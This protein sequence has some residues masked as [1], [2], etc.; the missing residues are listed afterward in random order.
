MNACG[1]AVNPS[2]HRRHPFAANA[3]HRSSTY[4]SL[5]GTRIL[6]GLG[7]RGL[8]GSGR[9]VGGNVASLHTARVEG[10]FIDN[11]LA[12]ADKQGGVAARRDWNC[13]GDRRAGRKQLLWSEDG[14]SAAL[15]PGVINRS[16]PQWHLGRTV[17]PTEA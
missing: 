13:N 10:K 8:N 6:P 11:Q 3:V 14:Q 4:S 7:L 16:K 15:Q 9:Q 1:V 2:C 5:G 17:W 12:G